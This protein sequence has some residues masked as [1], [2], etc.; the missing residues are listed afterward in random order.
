MWFKNMQLFRL[1][2]PFNI[3]AEELNDKLQDDALTPCGRT[4]LYSFGWTSPFGKNN[5]VFVHGCNGYLLFSAAKEEKILPA[6][7]VKQALEEKVAEIEAAEGREVTRRQRQSLREEIHFTLLAQAFTRVRTTFAYLDPKNQLLIVDAS[8][9][10]RAEELTVLL[11]KAI[12]SLKLEPIKT[13]RPLRQVLTNWILNQRYPDQFELADS[14]EMLDA[15]KGN[16]IVKC[17]QHDLTAKEI[18]SH[19]RSGKHISWLALRWSEKLSFV[20]H[21]DVSIKSIKFLDLIKDARNEVNAETAEQQLDV[22][23]AIMT[24]EFAQLIQDV[25]AAC[26]GVVTED[27]TD[28]EVVA[29]EA[30]PA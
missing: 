26:G 22:D 11:R 25:F 6:A 9:R 12:G 21:D 28:H 15:E 19:L 13:Q 20:L 10:S 4:Q 2:E 24:A 16:G 18:A 7:V 1:V 17:Q 27:N 8:S 29:A 23:F 5:P 14:C 30:V 3:S